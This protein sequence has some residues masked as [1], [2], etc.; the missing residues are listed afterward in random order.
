MTKLRQ[1]LQAHFKKTHGQVFFQ[2]APD[3]ASFPHLVYNVETYGDGEGYQLVTLDI[4]G[5]DAPE[6][7]DT[8][9]LEMLMSMINAS[10]DKTTLIA[11]NMVVTFYLDRKLPLKDDDPR[12]KRRKYI[13]QGRLFERS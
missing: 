13:Y 8:T 12:I 7:G 2:Q 9:A 1:A 10:M 4:D 11:E 6:N 3:T 5:W